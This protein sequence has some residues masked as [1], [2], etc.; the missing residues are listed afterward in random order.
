MTTLDEIA[1]LRLALREKSIDPEHLRRAYVHRRAGRTK[2]SI[3]RLLL[4]NHLVPRSVLEQLCEAAK[5]EA[6]IVSQ[7]LQCPENHELL[8]RIL[9]SDPESQK[10]QNLRLGLCILKECVGVGGEASVYR[11]YHIAFQHDVVVKA[12]LPGAR[13]KAAGLD[14]LRKEA[15]L[16]S[17][18]NHPGI[19]KVYDFDVSGYIP[20]VV[21]DHVVGETLHQR[22]ERFGRLTAPEVVS[23]GYQVAVA[24]QAA[25]D[26]DMLHRDVK[27]SNIMVSTAGKAKV[28]DFGFARDLSVPGH[29]TATGFIVGTP[30]YTAPEYGQDNPIDG[31]ADLYSLGVT[32]YYALTGVLPFESRS[33]VRL[34]AMH[35]QDDFPPVS[36]HVPNAP[37]K[38]IKIIE[39]LLAKSPLERFTSAA[40]LAEVLIA[41]DTLK[42]PTTRAVTFENLSPSSLATEMPILDESEETAAYTSKIEEPDEFSQYNF[43]PQGLLQTFFEKDVSADSDSELPERR[44]FYPGSGNGDNGLDSDLWPKQS[45]T[46]ATDELPNSGADLPAFDPPPK[47]RNAISGKSKSRSSKRLTKSPSKDSS[48]LKVASAGDKDSKRVYCTACE[49]PV[50]KAKKILGNIVCLDC[51]G[52]VDEHRLCTACFGK[53]SDKQE[54]SVV[55]RRGRYCPFCVKRVILYCSHCRERFPL[56]EIAMGVAAEIKGKP[57]CGTCATSQE[58]SSVTPRSDGAGE[59]ELKPRPGSSR[60]RPVTKSSRRP[61]ARSGR[62]SRRGRRRR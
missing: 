60:V 53:I 2:R 43:I 14:R 44:F 4:K 21:F 57:Y 3:P 26:E 47:V 1:F 20:Y 52:H 55:F 8:L 29:I 31:R 16:C 6:A 7:E 5:S 25:H 22:I 41:H 28:I 35:L 24:L 10:V 51:A 33:I 11:A 9:A 23:L 18:L 59:E 27:P 62:V 38:L 54:R 45:Q 40:E 12:L 42:A 13:R 48:R 61:R 32:L 15:E 49:E 34:L 56:R 17:R 19:S 50:K 58:D 30:Y 46:R 39:K 37:P 36:K